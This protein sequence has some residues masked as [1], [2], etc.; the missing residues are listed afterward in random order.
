MKFFKLSLIILLSLTILSG[1]SAQGIIRGTVY[2]D[3]LAEPLIAATVAVLETST[4]TDT[5]FDGTFEIQ[6]APGTYTLEVSYIGLQTI[7][8]TDVVVTEGEVTLFDNIRMEEESEIL[9]TVVVTSTA[10]RNTES[11][12][13]TIQRKSPN[14]L[15]GISSQSFKK[16]GDSDAASAVKRVTG[17]SVEGGKYVYVRGLGDRYTKTMLNGVDIPGLDPDRN[18][19]QIDIFPTNLI[20]NM[21]VAKTAVADMPAD[22]TGGVVN[23]ET[24]DFPE[25]KVFDVSAS[26]GYN[27]RMH[28][29]D[30][31]ITYPGSSTDGLGFDNGL[32]DLPDA[33]KQETI[34]SPISGDDDGVVNNFLNQFDRNL[35][36]VQ[37]PS[38]MDY[39]IGMTFANQMA[40]KKNTNKKLGYIVSG[41]YRNSTTFYDDL[42][43]GDYQIVS[44]DP[45]IFEL[46]YANRLQG[47]AGNNNVLLGGLAGLALK[48][49][50]AKYRLTAMHLQNGESEALQ[51]G[52]DNNDNATGQSGYTG[53]SDN[54]EY[55]QRS[56]TNILLNGKHYNEDGSF[57][58][59]WRISPTLSS[60]SDP[61]IRKTAYTDV[62]D[63]QTFVAGGGGN[64][65]RIWRSLEEVNLVGRLDATKEFAIGVNPAKLKLGAMQVVKERDYEILQYNIQFFGLQPSW[66]GDANEVL[67]PSNLFPS[68]VLYYSSGNAVPN[69][70]QY[71]AKVNNTAGYASL[72]FV[73]FGQL[74]AV[75]GLRAENFELRHTGRDQQGIN[76]LEDEVVVE[77][78]D[79][80]PSANLIYPISG[81]S[82]LRL[83]YS[84]TI[85]RPSFKEASFAQILDPK[86]NRSFNGG[87]FPLDDWDGNL[88]PTDINNFDLR[89]E[90]FGNRTEMISLSGFY[91][92]FTD[93]LEIVRI[94]QSQTN[95]AVQPRNVGDGTIIGMELEFR[96]K[97]NFL[98]ESL[99]AIQFTGNVTVAES[100]IERTAMELRSLESTARTGQTIEDTREMAGQAPYTINAGLA[101]SRPDGGLDAGLF[102]NVKGPTL[103]IVGAG[104]T[105][106][107][108]SQPFHSLNFNLNTNVNDKLSLNF[109]ISNI[110]G[111]VREDFFTGFQA[112]DQIYTRFSPGTEF[113]LGIKYSV[114]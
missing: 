93:P 65:S 55:G 6:V 4:G 78:F 19:L 30:E 1:I 75:L 48:G 87:L 99:S 36:A 20:S 58:I 74:K 45:S 71:N 72:E 28:F 25:E 76:V 44:T 15:D 47:V 26:I 13:L 68:G 82:N 100:S 84:K 101:Y 96:K 10:I 8:I 33:A 103:L 29:N 50:K 102:Y 11:A 109:K 35:G 104:I 34:P 49:E 31:Y 61:D 24:K 43:Y 37:E 70:N 106:N 42:F 111:D 73:P 56:L 59:D 98:S 112:A 46:N 62:G 60:M 80:F 66:S 77:G 89:W 12:L 3:A 107:V 114:F 9:E 105:P 32:R 5:D 63:R 90:L 23:I 67:D 38:F 85:A 2:D 64:P 41:T 52:L 79:L 110:L 51:L 94:T 7:T 57:T 92:A 27:P 16:I 14:V 113:G 95:V 81:Q 22:F 54:L 21:F 97:L 88:R 18:S 17:V 108:F 53:K 91:K 69:P 39:S 40:L 86:S 83:S